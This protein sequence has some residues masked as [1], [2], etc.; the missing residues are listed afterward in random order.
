[1]S[2]KIK[3]MLLA[4]AIVAVV[5]LIMWGIVELIIHL[6]ESETWQIILMIIVGFIIS[7]I[8]SFI[9]IKNDGTVTDKKDSEVSE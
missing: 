7:N 8:I 2:D 1:M 6:F 4:N 3:T 5:I 9:S